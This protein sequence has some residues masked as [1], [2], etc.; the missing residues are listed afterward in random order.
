MYIDTAIYVCVRMCVYVYV[1][2]CVRESV[3]TCAC[4]QLRTWYSHIRTRLR[5]Y[6]HA[7]THTCTRTH[8]NAHEHTHTHTRTQEDRP[9]YLKEQ[10][11]TWNNWKAEKRAKK[12][13]RIHENHGSEIERDF[14]FSGLAVTSARTQPHNYTHTDLLLSLP[15][16]FSL[17]LSFCPPATSYQSLF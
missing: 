4:V 5:T 2:V 12:A 6:A 13:A 17:S 8:T 3:C 9:E 16:S 15:P 1:W 11:D 14:L 7:H 10:E